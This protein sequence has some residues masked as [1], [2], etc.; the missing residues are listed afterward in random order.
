MANGSQRLLYTYQIED[1]ANNILANTLA[2]GMM[3]IYDN[4][5]LVLANSG[6]LTFNNTISVNALVTTNGTAIN[7]AFSLNTN[8]NLISLNTSTIIGTGNLLAT[9]NINAGNLGISQNA[10]FGNIGTANLSVNTNAS[11]GNIGVT[12]N[13]SFGNISTANIV[14]TN[15]ITQFANSGVYVAGTLVANNPN[16]NFVAANTSNLSITGTSNTSP[17][18]V[19]ITLDTRVA[20]G[21]GGGTPGGSNQQIQFNNTGAFGGQANL[22]YN[23]AQNTMSVE[24]N[25]MLAN[26]SNL[27]FGGGQGNTANANFFIFANTSSNSLDIWWS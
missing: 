21:G 25:V 15:P 17:G 9:Y 14:V 19:T 22:V 26:A 6:N 13:A 16:I 10:T 20:G 12:Q 8:A 11:F 4:A 2:N 18:N 24:G 7:V 27:Y 5:G 1:Q 23:V 3:A